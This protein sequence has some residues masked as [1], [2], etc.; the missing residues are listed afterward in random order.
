MVA[1]TTRSTCN[2]DGS[3]DMRVLLLL[4]LIFLRAGGVAAQGLQEV[5]V[6]GPNPG[7]LRMFVL[8]PPAANE[9][10]ASLPM[11]VALHGCGQTAEELLD[12]S[13]WGKLADLRGFILLC[14]QQ[15]GVNNMAQCFDWFRYRDAQGPD[16]E[17]ASIMAMVGQAMRT[18]PVD[19]GRVFVYGV[20]AGAAMAVNL[21]VAHPAVFKGGAVIAGGPF[22]G[23]V[24]AFAAMRTMMDPVDRTPDEWRG[25]VDRS[26]PGIT[27]PWPPLIVMH[28]LKDHVVDPRASDELVDQWA[29]LNGMDTTPEEVANDLGGHPGIAQYIYRDSSGRAA[30]TSYVFKDLGH[31]L[32]IDAGDGPCQGGSPGPRSIDIGFHSTCVIADGFGL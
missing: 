17:A 28:G 26:F 19:T 24:S 15:R 31:A 6:P 22:L 29:G 4:F 21:L 9:A 12:I 18:M 10:R 2:V 14:P 5:D 23:D 25:I 7:K 16:G 11:V 13:G 32:A 27:G 20:S 3:L 30:V 8:L 1:C